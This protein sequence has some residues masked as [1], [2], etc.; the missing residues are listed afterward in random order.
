MASD[1]ESKK[2]AKPY[3]KLSQKSHSLSELCILR[4]WGILSRNWQGQ[5]P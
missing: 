4:I 5:T 3:I 2:E 1:S